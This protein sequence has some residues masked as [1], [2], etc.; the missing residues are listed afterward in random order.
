MALYPVVKPDDT[1]RKLHD[2]C[3]AATKQASVKQRFVT[4]FFEEIA[5]RF[6]VVISPHP[7]VGIRLV[8]RANVNFTWLHF[9]P[10][11]SQH[12]DV[13]TISTPDKVI[14]RVRT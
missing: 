13:G 5:I 9:C 12:L 11:F 4:M 2:V 3:T 7:F 1:V 8:L 10:G 14:L 6:A